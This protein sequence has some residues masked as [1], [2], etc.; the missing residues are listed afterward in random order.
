MLILGIDPSPTEIPSL[1]KTNEAVDILDWGTDIMSQSVDYIGGVK[2][3][4]AYFESYGLR[5]LQALAALIAVAKEHGLQVIMDAKRGDIGATS[6]AYALAYLGDK[7]NAGTAEFSCD[8]LTVNP[9]MGDD[10]LQP[11][12]NVAAQHNKGIFVL[13]ETSN[14]GADM[15][16]KQPLANGNTVSSAIADYIQTQHHKLNIAAGAFGP[17]GVVVGATNPNVAQWRALLP[18]SI[19]LMPGIG[20]QGGAWDA[21]KDGLNANGKGVMV[22]ISRGITSVTQPVQSKAEYLDHVQKNA[23]KMEDQLKQVL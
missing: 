7:N 19:F 15:I 10:C 18:H 16:L 21:V 2:F 13:L 23:K 11:F 22:P 3:Q 12:V 4:S 20:A 14:P 17:I 9:L 5:G 6:L 1:Y 8:Y